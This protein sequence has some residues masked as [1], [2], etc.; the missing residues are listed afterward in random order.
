[1]RGALLFLRY[2]SA[3]V[4]IQKQGMSPTS[5]VSASLSSGVVSIWPPSV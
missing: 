3:S 4:V 1:M 2:G 5:K